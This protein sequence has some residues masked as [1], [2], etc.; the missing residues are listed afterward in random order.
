MSG[1]SERQFRDAMSVYE[2]QFESLDIK[3]IQHWAETLHIES[4]WKRLRDE[5]HPLE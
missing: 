3:Y 2:L 4:F 1:G 5:A